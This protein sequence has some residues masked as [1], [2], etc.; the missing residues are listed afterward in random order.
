M[1]HLWAFTVD[2]PYVSTELLLKFRKKQLE[3]KL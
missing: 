1:E 2:L 3:R